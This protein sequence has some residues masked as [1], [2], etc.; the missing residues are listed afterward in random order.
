MH[1]FPRIVPAVVI[2]RGILNRLLL[3]HKRAND[4]RQGNYDS[5]YTTILYHIDKH[6]L[7]LSKLK[8]SIRY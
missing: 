5:V 8:I 4:T 2:K 1:A 7:D 3:V 6:M